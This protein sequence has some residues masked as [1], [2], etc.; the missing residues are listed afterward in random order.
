MRKHAEDLAA[1]WQFYTNFA[2][3]KIE[4]QCAIFK[5]Y[6]HKTVALH[7]PSFYI[8]MNHFDIAFHI[9]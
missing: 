9:T 4:I 5:R 3:F 2:V 7:T 8:K 1:I 6:L